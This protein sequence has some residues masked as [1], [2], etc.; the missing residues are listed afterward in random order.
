[1]RKEIRTSY[2]HFN[3]MV[4]SLVKL[5]NRAWPWNDQNKVRTEM[6]AMRS[7]RSVGYDIVQ[8]NTEI[9]D[10]L[11]SIIQLSGSELHHSWAT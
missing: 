3:K 6:E 5:F 4:S 11:K 9:R 2:R 10:K 1:M 7:L 8:R